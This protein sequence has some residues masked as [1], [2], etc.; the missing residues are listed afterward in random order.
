MVIV[1]D[2]FGGMVGFVIL[3]DILEEIVG[4]IW[5]EYDEVVKYVYQIG[6]KEYE[7]NVDIFIDEFLIY[8]V[9]SFFDSMCYILGGW[10][11]EQFDYIFVKGDFFL[12]EE[13]LFIIKEVEN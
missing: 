13:I 3:E 10:I 6:E 4:E 11:Y 12:Y 7:F 2:E 1:V 5:D 9:V 8:I